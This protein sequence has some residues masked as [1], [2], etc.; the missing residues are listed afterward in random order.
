MMESN[1]IILSK[2]DA[3]I[4]KFYK[5]ELIKGLLLG[6]AGIVSA[7]LLASGLEYLG[8]FG[9]N[10]RTILFWSWLAF[11]LF[12][13][14]KYIFIPLAHLY[15]IG[16]VLDHQS[17]AR[18]VGS[19]F[20]DIQDKLLN[21]L[22]L[23]DQRNAAGADELLQAA[24]DQRIDALK[25]VPFQ[26]AVDLKSNI[27]YARLAILPVVALIVILLL[28]PGFTDSSRRL[29]NY[30][31]FYQKQA[32][33]YFVLQNDHLEAIQNDDYELAVITEG[34][35]EPKEIYVENNGNRFKM[36]KDDDG[37]FRYLLRNVQKDIEF[38]FN[39]EGF[40]SQPYELNVVPK[41]LLLDFEARME[42]PAYTG[43]KNEMLKNIGDMTV[44]AGTRI[45][46]KFNTRNVEKLSL[47][48]NN[49]PQTAEKTSDDSYQTLKRFLQSEVMTLK[50]ANGH[51]QSNDSVRYAINVIPDT[52]PQIDFKQRKDSLSA[53]LFYFIGELN[54]DYGISKLTFNYRFTES[55]DQGKSSGGYKTVPIKL[56]TNQKNQTFYYYW[57]LN[58]LNVKSADKVEYYFEVWDNDGVHGSKST[59]TVSNMYAAPTAKEIDKETEEK[60]QEIKA[61]LKDNMKDLKKLNEEIKKIQEK[62][63][64]KKTLNWE[65]KK[66]IEEMLKKHQEL[67]EK[68]KDVVKEN[69]QKNNKENEFKNVDKEI[70]EKQKELEKLFKEVMTD[71]MKE[72]MD[73]IKELM[74]QNNKDQLQDQLDKFKFND[75]EM[76]KQMDRMLELFKELELEKKM[77]ES[78]DKLDKLAE[79][80][81]KLSKETEQGKKE[82]K[83]LEKKQDELSKKF[84]DLKKDIKDIEKKNEELAKPQEMEKTDKE[85]KEIEKEMKESQENL[86]KQQ[87]SK[88]GQNQK[89]AAE[90]MKELGEKMESAMKKNK[91]KKHVEDY[92]TLREIL[93]NLVQVSKDQ[94]GLMEEFKVVKDYNP[95]Y[96]EMGQLQ[97]KVKD[98]TKMIE[99]SLLA[100]S[101]RVPEIS[102]F[103]NKEIGLVNL[104]IEKS[105]YFVGERQTPWIVNHQQQ[106]MTSMNNLAL[107]LSDILKQMQDDMKKESSGSCDNPGGA[108][109]KNPSFGNLKEMQDGLAKKLQQLSKGQQQGQQPSSKDFAEAMAQ[110]AAI[111][112]KLKDLQNQLEKEGKGGGKL[113]NLDETQRMMDQLEREL[114]NKRLNP[115]MLNKQQE[116]LHRLLEHDKAERKQDQDDQRKAN[117]GK[118]FKRDLPPSLQEYL[119]EKEKEQELLRTLPPDLSPYYKDR[120][121][122]YFKQIGA[123]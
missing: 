95:R 32:P 103:V 64:E 61:D 28:F 81:K 109:K 77:K 18:I 113:G 53:K 40:Y 85:Q 7:F 22:Q 30:G 71:E 16:K 86:E 43:K 100:L 75:K 123:E 76:A 63:T 27:K 73:K 102:N 121:R 56:S 88:A 44:P 42:Y 11:S 47:F 117:Q 5:N 108:G 91:E 110:Q 1:N 89:K 96:V 66:Q 35:A 33:F 34:N 107:M 57:N 45:Q 72:L 59:R 74:M 41:P 116:I 25:P 94:E 3:F 122:D 60:N 87:N 114:A 106:A 101:K 4:R 115:E 21:T 80:Q 17:A 26:S 58:D 120:V 97:K 78:I 31:T 38:S 49:E 23:E 79:E 62:L 13:A 65:D 99:D 67:Q 46:W 70:Q 68:M 119:K 54:D 20:P 10:L 2:L 37:V 51:M 90:K 6:V 69:Q 15:K 29:V 111:R 52:Y 112:K 39:A 118:D 105:L 93:E 36:R 55:E 9:T 12:V 19:H 84:D 92:N 48:F 50:T 24:I 83:E 104:N 82:N 8:Q 98:D 14:V